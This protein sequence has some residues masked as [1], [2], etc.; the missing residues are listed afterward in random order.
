MCPSEN[1]RRAALTKVDVRHGADA[2][3]LLAMWLAGGPRSS[4]ELHELAAAEGVTPKRLRSARERLGVIV[5]R[6]GN[7]RLM[8]ATWS[9]PSALG[10]GYGSTSA[11][12]PYGTR[13][14]GDQSKPR[15]EPIYS[16]GELLRISRRI[17]YLIAKGIDDVAAHDLA[18]HLVIARDRLGARSGSCIECQ[19]WRPV[20]QRPCSEGQRQPVEIWDCSWRRHDAP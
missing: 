12:H 17:P 8:R 1:Q 13:S 3:Q 16:S 20:G 4:R 14:Q 11:D 15:E 10:L 6:S 9:L 7:R 18:V 19:N 5:R 2:A